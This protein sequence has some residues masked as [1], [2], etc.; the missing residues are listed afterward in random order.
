MKVA[1][2]GAGLSGLCCAHELEQLNIEP[3]VYEKRSYVSQ[4]YPHVSCILKA[5]HRPVRD[6]LRYFNNNM[7][8]SVTPLNTVNTIIHHSPKKTVIIKGRFG[9]FFKHLNDSDSFSNQVYSSLKSTHI[10]TSREGDFKKLA[11][12]YDYVVAATGSSAAA[13]EVGCWQEWQ[14]FYTKGA[15]ILGN[16]D[17][18][19]LIIWLN[20]DYCKNGY[21]YLAPF[22]KKK[23]SLV[24]VVTDVNERDTDQYWKTFIYRENI[25]YDIIEEFRFEHK[26]G[27]VYPLKYN[28]LLFVGNAAGGY[29]PFFGAGHVNAVTMGVC[30]ARSIAKGTDY[31]MQIKDSIE[32]NKKIKK[33]M[34]KFSRLDNNDYD[35]IVGATGLPGM[36]HLLYG[37][38]VDTSKYGTYISQI[39]LKH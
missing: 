7:N 20:K 35:K 1:I 11:K 28:N 17:P 23:A 33:C 32:R 10:K 14:Q 37:F 4:I 30:A 5:A 3:V 29:E 21:A 31:A 38:P 16:F 6:S 19:T 25:Q 15:V 13:E 34:N 36:K 18:N 9:Y 2:I 24:L 12:Q 26:S 27:Y 39:F 22:S 8:I